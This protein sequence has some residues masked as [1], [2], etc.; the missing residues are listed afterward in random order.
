MYILLQFIQ[1]LVTTKEQEEYYRI[2]AE[3]S[4]LEDEKRIKFM[5]NA[6]RKGVMNVRSMFP[7]FHPTI[8]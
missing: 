5:K 3:F 7:P 8:P 4:K 1:F 2:Q 6:L